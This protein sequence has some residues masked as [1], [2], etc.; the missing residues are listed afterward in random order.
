MSVVL[1]TSM[2]RLVI[3]VFNR[4]PPMDCDLYS[5]HWYKISITSERRQRFVFLVYLWFLLWSLCNE[6]HVP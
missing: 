5:R 1:M 3:K 4:F 6:N 2:L